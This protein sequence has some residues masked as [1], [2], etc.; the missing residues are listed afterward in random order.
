MEILWKRG[1]IKK[2]KKKEDE[3]GWVWRCQFKPRQRSI[4][5]SIWA[6]AHFCAAVWLSTL[7]SSYLSIAATTGKCLLFTTSLFAHHRHS[8][9]GFQA[10][11]PLRHT[12][13]TRIFVVACTHLSPSPSPHPHWVYLVFKLKT[14]C[15][16][17]QALLVV[18][19]KSP[20]A[21][22][23]L[24]APAVT[25]MCSFMT[26]LCLAAFVIRDHSWSVE[27]PAS[28]QRGVKPW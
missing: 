21:C 22:L 8:W 13:S 12:A 20:T 11:A 24:S 28:G 15:R 16:E 23:T 9:E 5:V 10:V 14:P 4:S 19:I 26:H 7:T 25:Q 2:K 27:S 18:C 3:T 1:K 17:K 6:P